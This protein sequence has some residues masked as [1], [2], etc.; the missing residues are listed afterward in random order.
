M[1]TL[2]VGAGRTDEEYK[3]AE[4]QRRADL[5][6]DGKGAANYFF[7]AAVTAALGTGVL[8]LRINVGTS[9]GTIDCLAL[10]GGGLTRHPWPSGLLPRYGWLPYC[11]LRLPPERETAGLFWWV[12]FF[13]RLTWSRSP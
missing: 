3:A 4:E 2:N 9:I 12:S 8:P 5:L 6:E 13:T 7:A 10:Y 1:Q 11:C